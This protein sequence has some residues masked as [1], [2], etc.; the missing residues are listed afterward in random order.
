[1]YQEVLTRTEQEHF[2]RT[3][4]T[5]FFEGVDLKDGSVF[6]A[7]IGE[8]FAV[9]EVDY[10]YA[11]IMPGGPYVISTFTEDPRDLGFGVC[12]PDAWVDQ[13]KDL[14][15]LNTVK[16]LCA[17]AAVPGMFYD[18]GS[19]DEEEL[20]ILKSRA[21]NKVVGLKC[22]DDRP[23]SAM[24]GP[25]PEPR[26][27]PEVFAVAG[28]AMQLIERLSGMGSTRL[29]GGD[30]ARTA[31]ASALIDQAIS[32]MTQQAAVVVDRAVTTIVRYALRLARSY[33]RKITVQGICGSEVTEVWPD[34]GFTLG[35][36]KDDRGVDIVVGTMR[37]ASTDVE[38]KLLGDLYVA[39]AKDPAV[40]VS[41]RLD[42]LDYIT[43]L[44]GAP[45]D[46]SRAIELAANA[47]PMPMGPGGGPAQGGGAP[48]PNDIM[49][50]V[51]NT[52]GGR[53]PTGAGAGDNM[54][55]AR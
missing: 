46:L 29:S 10:S 51:I 22:P 8:D 39:M 38:L 20:A 54:R 4:L 45:I 53:L 48:V 18:K 16:V 25:L 15:I 43:N 49:Q 32:A 3:P 33:Y 30:T 27:T 50:G 14:S 26:I 6:T 5:M 23:V 12:Q 28:E 36:I 41:I 55:V 11:S 34:K 24:Y 13:Q 21:V 1:V 42:L 31:T 7:P 19:I 47:P 9:R 40:P 52:G 2:A 35:E 17:K 37:R 44:Y